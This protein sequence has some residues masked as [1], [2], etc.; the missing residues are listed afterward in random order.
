VDANHLRKVILDVD[1]GNI[2]HPILGHFPF[3][4]SPIGVEPL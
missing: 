2:V 1:F 4:N 3:H